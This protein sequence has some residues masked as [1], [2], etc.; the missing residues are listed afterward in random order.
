MMS[1]MLTTLTERGQVSM[2]SSLRREMGLRPG[3][4]L[5]WKR[6][7]DREVRVT[8]PGKGEIRSMRG[9]IKKFHRPALPSTT[10]A[11]LKLLREG[12]GR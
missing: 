4:P 7:S 9:F 3:Q 5:L 2:P 6:V 1:G 11:W 10:A 8:V 12:E